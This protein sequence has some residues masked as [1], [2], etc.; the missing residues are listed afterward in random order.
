MSAILY[1]SGFNTVAVD[2]VTQKM[3]SGEDGESERA[4]DD[5]RIT[6]LHEVPV[7]G[8]FEE[9]AV[10]ESAPFEEGA[11]LF[12]VDEGIIGKSFQNGESIIV[13]NASENEDAEPSHQ[14]IVSGISV[15]LED[16]AVF[17]G[18]SSEVGAFDESDAEVAEL[19]CTHATAALDRIERD[20]ELQRKNERLEQ[21]ASF[22]SHDLRNPLN[23]A[24][25]R[26]EL[27]R[28]E[29]DSDHLDDV[30][31][32]IDRMET[33]IDE[34]LSLAKAGRQLND[35]EPVDLSALAQT[36]WETVDTSDAT[37]VT[38]TEQR[39]H[40]DPNR[41]RQ[42]LENLVRNS[43]EHSSAHPDSRANEESDRGGEGVTIR[44]GDI[45][46]GGFYV[47][48]DGPGIPEDRRERVFE[49]G[50]STSD[51]GTGYGLA[52]IEEI[53]EAHDWSVTVTESVDR[54]ARFEIRT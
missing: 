52:I 22:V 53:V 19:L 9:R 16:R 20:R 37:L 4:P 42:L 7:D 41:L 14:P 27:V 21:F 34:L 45:E 5:E 32:A 25:L 29:C 36:C 39:I 26:L 15:P 54:G 43:V 38:E 3:G 13:E 33:L 24:D 6:R 2:S 30:T 12:Q 11:R 50:Y 28:A 31:Q 23:V 46:S 10:S 18:Y 35:V 44:I 47:A 8:M 17:Q 48:D 1:M 40:A 49:S 51:S